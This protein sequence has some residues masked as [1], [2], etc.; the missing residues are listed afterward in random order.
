[1]ANSPS[2]STQ[3]SGLLQQAVAALGSY[4]GTLTSQ[5]PAP[6]SSLTSL[7]GLTNLDTALAAR[8]A[9]YI[10]QQLGSSEY[11]QVGGGLGLRHRQIPPQHCTA[12]SVASPSLGLGAVTMYC[13]P[14]VSA[15][16]AERLASLQTGCSTESAW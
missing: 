6:V 5:L 12:C 2:G 8:A 1:V 9:T 7:H 4:R 10:L 16:R 3:L 15:V 13:R 14:C 11:R